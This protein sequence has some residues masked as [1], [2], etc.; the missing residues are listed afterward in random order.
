MRGLLLTR[1]VGGRDGG[2]VQRGAPGPAAQPPLTPFRS[3]AA[4]LGVT[5]P[6]ACI[7]AA[8]GQE[9]SGHLV[10]GLGLGVAGAEQAGGTGSTAVAGPGWRDPLGPDPA[11]HRPDRV[12]RR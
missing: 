7:A 2:G 10:D 12:S 9:V 6:Q 3:T 8:A 1:G 11:A 5:W 4:C